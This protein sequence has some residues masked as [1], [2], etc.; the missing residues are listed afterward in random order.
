MDPKIREMF[1]IQ[2]AQIASLIES[3]QKKEQT[4]AQIL[5]MFCDIQKKLQN[6]YFV[7]V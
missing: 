5:N 2:Q 1:D 6:P 7:Y 4:M 3:D